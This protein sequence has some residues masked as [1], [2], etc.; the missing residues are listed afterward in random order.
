MKE[1]INIK[2]L[3]KADGVDE[4][5]MVVAEYGDYT[6]IYRFTSFE[7]WVAAWCY[8]KEEGYWSQGHY[9][10]TLEGALSYIALMDNKVKKHYIST[11]INICDREEKTE[12]ADM[13]AEVI[14][15][16]WGDENE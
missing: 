1:F 13:M 10:Q 3:P 16:K 4:R 6:L 14:S 12:V 2:D 15:E 9:Y 7:P 11:A 5:Y 8:H